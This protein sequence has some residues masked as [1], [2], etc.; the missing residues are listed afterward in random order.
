M[1]DAAKLYAIVCPEERDVDTV[2]QVL[3]AVDNTKARGI[4]FTVQALGK[5]I[6]F[7]TRQ[8]L[9]ETSTDDTLKDVVAHLQDL[10]VALIAM[11]PSDSWLVTAKSMV[12]TL[13]RL[14]GLAAARLNI[15]SAHIFAKLLMVFTVAWH[16]CVATA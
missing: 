2:R 3:D 13:A 1:M 4:L 12:E 16:N 5:H 9:S 10:T 14:E 7:K 8:N 11:A 6:T 15:V